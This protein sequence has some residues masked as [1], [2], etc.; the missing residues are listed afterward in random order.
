M[1]KIAFNVSKIKNTLYPKVY[2]KR[3]KL[4][5]H[6]WVKIIVINKLYRYSQGSNDHAIFSYYVFYIPVFL[7]VYS[8][9]FISN[10]SKPMA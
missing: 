4:Y 10:N 9:K 3:D 5:N 7:C 1:K 2:F 8:I 6:R